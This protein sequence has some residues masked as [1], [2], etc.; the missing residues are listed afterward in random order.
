MDNKS[1]EEEALMKNLMEELPMSSEMPPHVRTKAI[2]IAVENNRRATAARRPRSVA[3]LT[4]GIAVLAVGTILAL[5]K[6]AAA[7]TWTMVA[8]A[9]QKIT[10]FQMD[11]RATEGNGK[12]EEVHIAMKGDEMLI[13]AGD[14]AQVYFG[15][16]GMQVYD[17]DKNTVMKMQLPVEVTSFM[18]MLADEITKSF[19]LKKEIAE[20][21]AKYGKDQ[22]QILPFREENGRRVYDVRMSD[23]DG[24][25]KAFL[26]VDADTDLPIF[27]DASG[28]KDGERVQINLRYNDAIT[29]KPNFPANAKVEEIDMSKMMDGE[30][31]GKGMEHFGRDMEKMF[32]GFGKG[33]EKSFNKEGHG[34]EGHEVKIRL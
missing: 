12:V 17:A 30:K 5:P 22:I 3:W 7:K 10:S 21:E 28:D 2:N 27:I 29:I 34:K 26:T 19:S 1:W 24:G 18:P 6:P 31:I 13:D 4:A 23:P 11:L 8:Q 33:M 32:E 25:G 14:K 9:V 15:K 20:M 16:D